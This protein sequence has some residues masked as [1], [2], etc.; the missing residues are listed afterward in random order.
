MDNYSFIIILLDNNIV[1]RCVSFSYFV[2]HAFAV[3]K[4]QNRSKAVEK[5]NESRF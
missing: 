1:F 3:Q 4:L 2:L 5:Q